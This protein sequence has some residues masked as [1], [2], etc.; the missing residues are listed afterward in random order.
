MVYEQRAP[1]RPDPGDPLGLWI[2]RVQRADGSI[3]EVEPDPGDWYVVIDDLAYGRIVFD[4]AR[5]PMVDRQGRL[6]FEPRRETRT[7]ELD[8]AQ[9]AADEARSSAALGQEQRPLRIG[10]AFLVRGPELP[11]D[12]REW[13]ILADLTRAAREA[14]K[15]ALFAAVAP[16][17]EPGEA[18][19]LP[20]PSDTS[21]GDGEA[22]GGAAS[23]AFP[24]V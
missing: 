10:D 21:E 5:W 12:I 20:E 11:T 18:E 23:Q 16:R 24:A 9:A 14:A 1:S 17:L 6:V 8:R 22:A 15:L 19:R 13:A 4:A 2:P 3:E 7:V